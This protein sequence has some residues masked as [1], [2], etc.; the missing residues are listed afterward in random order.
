MQSLDLGKTHTARKMCT[1]ISDIPVVWY[2]IISCMPFCTGELYS[3]WRSINLLLQYTFLE[4]KF[5][6][7]KARNEHCPVNKRKLS[8]IEL[9]KLLT[10]KLNRPWSD[11]SVVASDLVAHFLCPQ[12]NFG[13]HIEIA[14]SV[15]LSVLPSVCPSITNDVSAIAH[16]LLKQIWWNF[17]DR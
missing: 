14:L 13:R 5:A 8:C 16:K 7:G 15:L 2:Q 9:I 6:K 4:N 1:W 17:T 11:F 10:G 12:R 3:T